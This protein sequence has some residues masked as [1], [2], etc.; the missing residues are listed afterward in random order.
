VSCERAAAPMIRLLRGPL[1]GWNGHTK[2]REHL[3]SVTTIMKLSDEYED[4]EAKLDRVHPRYDET[5]ALPLFDKD[6]DPA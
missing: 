5:P 2:M 3:A 6:G 4:F 1:V